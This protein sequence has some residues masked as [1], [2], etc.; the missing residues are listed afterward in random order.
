MRTFLTVAAMAA[1]MAAAPVRAETSPEVLVRET[2]EQI[3]VVLRENNARY[4]KDRKALY[5]MVDERVLPHFDFRKM[6]QLVLGLGWRQASEAQRDRFTDEFRRL[7]VRTYATALLKY[8]DQKIIFLPY[9]GKPEDKIAVVKTEIRQTGGGVNIPLY[10]TFY[11]TA[12]GWKVFDLTV[13]GVSLVTN[14][15]KVYGE[16]LQTETLD[17]LIASLV[18]TN[19]KA[20]SGTGK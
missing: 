4:Q 19:R 20:G 1:T 7:L 10:Y 2:T 15:R 16:R 11:N 5:A 18:E 12:P 3:L 17:S 13:E 9:T 14:Y 8:T 6:A